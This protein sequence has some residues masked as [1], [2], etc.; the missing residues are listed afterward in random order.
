[1][2]PFFL[3]VD[4]SNY[5]TSA[6]LVNS[7]GE[8]FSSKRLLAVKPG[9]RGVR[10]S[11]ALFCHTR[12]LGEILREAFAALREKHPD[13]AVAGV[14]V[15]A[16]P[17]EEEGSYMPCFLAGMNAARAVS[18]AL[19]VPL[20]KTTHQEGHLAAAAFGS[21][22]EG[23]P[24]PDGPFLALHLSG[25]TGELLRAVPRRSGYAVERPARFLDITP[26]QLIDRCGV[27]LGLPFP[28]GAALEK[29]AEQ[30]RWTGRIRPAVKAD[31]VALSGFENRFEDLLSEG[32]SRENA[33]A[34]VFAAVEAGV[35]A[36]LTLADGEER[37]LPVLFS[38][39]VSSSRLLRERLGADNH[40]FTAPDLAADNAVGV[41]LITRNTITG[42]A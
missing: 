35:R 3:G 12:D 38:G 42:E 28:A 37:T 11:E 6:A 10:Q 5:T 2:T 29:L 13:A 40:Y 30:G 7:A 16:R 33:A 4:T 18:V 19:D 34:F 26:G 22:R 15:S 1:M 32:A 20:I 25:G 8:V 39:G 9:E 23:R 31:G 27:K 41:A 24:L 36:L 21:A 17:R 14:G